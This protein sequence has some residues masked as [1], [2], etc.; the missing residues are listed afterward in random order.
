MAL[1]RAFPL[2]LLALAGC[3]RVQWDD[4]ITSTGPVRA[5]ERGVGAFAAIELNDR[6][7]LVLEERP[8]GA[9]AVEA[10]ANLLGQVRTEAADG[11]LRISNGNRCNW[12][13]SFKPRITV[14][15][16]VQGLCSL[17]VRGT[18]N[19]LCRD[20]LRCAHFHLEQW[21]A[22][23]DCQL[24][25]SGPRID[26]GLHS[27]AGACAV[28][29]RCATTFLYSGIMGGID[30]NG[31]R[32]GTVNINNSSVADFRCWAVD[33]LYAQVRSAGDVYYR[34]D[35]GVLASEVTGSG[36]LIRME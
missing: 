9:I 10:G 4:C 14:R 24:L 5:E 11:V 21:D 28:S 8:A 27:G 18:G 20:T 26:I 2:L 15:A 1:T 34:G 22:E 7:D 25:Y 32:A 33:A 6:I 16:P 35:P 30:A 29:G 12:V 13:R 19:V 36:R 17:A 31:L 3:Q 23:G